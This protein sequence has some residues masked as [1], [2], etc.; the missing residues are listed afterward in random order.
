MGR[1]N[2]SKV[3]GKGAFYKRMR[4]DRPGIQDVDIRKEWDIRT[5]A[6]KAGAVKA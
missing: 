1:K 6:K 5:A 2:K 3:D 4:K